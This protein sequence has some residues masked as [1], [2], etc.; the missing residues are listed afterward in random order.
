MQLLESRE[1]KE[2]SLV[3][4]FQ[5]QWVVPR[6]RGMDFRDKA[7]TLLLY[8]LLYGNGWWVMGDVIRDVKRL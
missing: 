1:R 6:S 5:L 4:T 7:T 8:G 2:E 3:V